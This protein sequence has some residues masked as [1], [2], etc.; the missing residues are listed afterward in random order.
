MKTVDY[1][2]L[3]NEDDKENCVVHITFRAVDKKEYECV[4]V[5]MK[6]TK[7]IIQVAF[8]AKNDKVA[9][10]YLDIKISDIISI[11]ILKTSNIVEL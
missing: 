9:K 4:G 10:D 3:L 7:K 5:L 1:K 11:N 8:N 2:K 6:E